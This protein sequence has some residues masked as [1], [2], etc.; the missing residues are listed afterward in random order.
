M[1][2]RIALRFR[3]A[4]MTGAAV[5]GAH[6]HCRTLVTAGSRPATDPAETSRP[7]TKMGLDKDTLYIAGGLAAIGAIWYYYAMMENARI[8]KKREGLKS[9]SATASVANAEGSRGRP[10]EDATPP[11]KSRAL[12]VSKDAQ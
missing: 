1:S 6:T 3:L 7:K 5:Q 12:G 4:R 10:A 9:R 2:Y 8:E 11:T